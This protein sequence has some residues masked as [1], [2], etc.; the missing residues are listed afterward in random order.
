MYARADPRPGCRRRKTA[1]PLAA[2]RRLCACD[3]DRLRAV[4]ARQG[5][6]ACA[7]S[8][9]ASTSNSASADVEELA[10]E[11]GS[12][13]VVLS[14]LRRHVQLRSQATRARMLR[15]TRSGGRIGLANWTPMASSGTVQDRGHVPAAPLRAKSPALWGTEPHIVE[16]FGAKGRRHPA[17]SRKPLQLSGY[18]S[19]PTGCR[20][21]GTTTGPLSKAFAAT[22]RGASEVPGGGHRRSAQTV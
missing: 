10:L 3:L 8:G 9:G 5:R 19:A 18:R 4:V 15:V 22:G 13:D 12:F 11:D 1:T 21:S 16:L 2:A 17:P 7:L 20:C 14:T 6:R